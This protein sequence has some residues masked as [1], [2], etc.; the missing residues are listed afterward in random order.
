ML[1]EYPALTYTYHLLYFGEVVVRTVH[2]FEFFNLFVIEVLADPLEFLLG[3]PRGNPFIMDY[4]FL[5]FRGEKRVALYFS[6]LALYE[7]Y[8]FEFIAL[9]YAFH[10]FLELPY[11]LRDHIVFSNLCLEHSLLHFIAQRNSLLVK[12]VL[13]HRKNYFFD[14]FDAVD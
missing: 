12:L 1:F 3:H 5:A 10:G 9:H 2:F 6:Q 11:E 8:F 7:V 13:E 14:F 4:H